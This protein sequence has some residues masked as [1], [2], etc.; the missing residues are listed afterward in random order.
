[1]LFSSPT[2]E[3]CWFICPKCLDQ[4][5]ESVS[6]LVA[7]CARTTEALRIRV[8]SGEGQSHEQGIPK[9][10]SSQTIEDQQEILLPEHENFYSRTQIVSDFE[11]AREEKFQGLDNDEVVDLIYK[12]DQFI[13]DYNKEVMETIERFGDGDDA[14]INRPLAQ[15]NLIDAGQRFVEGQP[16]YLL[17]YPAKIPTINHLPITAALRRMLDISGDK[18]LEISPNLDSLSFSQVHTAFVGWFV[19]DVLRNKL[20]IYGLPSM[21]PMRAMMAAVKEFAD[22]SKYDSLVLYSS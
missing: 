7:E 12:L 15:W 20:D 18:A 4:P 22:A 10:F 5:N 17:D 6:H 2:I 8:S 13:Y 3:K 16:W 1:M 9:D 19:I 14:W 21:K 11:P